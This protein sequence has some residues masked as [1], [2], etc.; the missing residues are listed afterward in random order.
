MKT[1]FAFL[2]GALAAYTILN[3]PRLIA[4]LFQDEPPAPPDWRAKFI[5]YTAG[6]PT[7]KESI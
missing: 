3:A 4:P 6:R 5:T 1:A 7:Y 2:L